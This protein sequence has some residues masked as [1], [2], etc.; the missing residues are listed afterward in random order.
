MEEYMSF[1]NIDFW[2]LIFTW[3]NLLVLFLLMKKFLFKP[4]RE[5][6]EKRERE[7]E[8][9]YEKANA[10]KSEAEKMRGEYESRL[11]AAKEDA[12]EIMK[13]ATQKAQLRSEEI[14]DEAK[15]QASD[16]LQKAD[17]QLVREKKNAMNEIK[18]EISGMAVAL[19]EKVIEKD[20]DEA[21]HSDLIDKFIDEIGD[22]S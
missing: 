13:N 8:E 7:V 22:A 19:A 3:G 18:N 6:I 20:I 1:V 12:G 21:A 11:A 10:E 2:T 9:I 17:R 16:I 15:K 14:I 5:L 4:V